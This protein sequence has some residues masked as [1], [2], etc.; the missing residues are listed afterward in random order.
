MERSGCNGQLFWYVGWRDVE[1]TASFERLQFP[2]CMRMAA[3]VG[4]WT[5]AA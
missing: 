2:K 3:N 1:E 4:G 5:R